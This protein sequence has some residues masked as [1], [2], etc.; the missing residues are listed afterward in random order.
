MGDDKPSDKKYIYELDSS[1]IIDNID[2]IAEH[3]KGGNIAVITKTTIQELDDVSKNYKKDSFVRRSASKASQFLAKL[4]SEGVINQ[5]ISSFLKGDSEK[6][7]KKM[8][9][10]GYVFWEPHF[11]VID[12]YPE[13]TPDN[14]IL[15]TAVH[16]QKLVKTLRDDYHVTLIS[17]DANLRLKA[18]SKDISTSTSLEEMVRHNPELGTK[19][20]KR[21]ELYK[22]YREAY[23]DKQCMDELIQSGKPHHRKLSI[24]K[25]QDYTNSDLSNLCWNEGVILIDREGNKHNTKILTRFNPKDGVIEDL[26]Y[27]VKWDNGQGMYKPKE[28]MGLT[29]GDPLQVYSFE[30]EM[31]PSIRLFISDGMWGTGKTLILMAGCLYNLFSQKQSEGSVGRAIR[32]ANKE[33]L[34]EQNLIILRPEYSSSEFELGPVPGNEED[35]VMPWLKPHI[36]AMK[37]IG[38]INN[39]DFYG[40]LTKNKALEP[41]T[42]AL[43]RGQNIEDIAFIDEVQNGNRHFARLLMGRISDH[44]KVFVSGCSYQIDNEY[45]N[46]Q[47][48]ALTLIK[49][50]YR[51]KGPSI[52]QITLNKNYR[53]N[54][55]RLADGI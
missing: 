24:K 32:K 40:D 37:K 3:T 9:N 51:G 15:G 55:S 12:S 38:N 47:T 42:T 45:V 6:S 28:M 23:V 34:K 30:F 27:A 26:R 31:D 4:L 13:K 10:G 14:R 43:L 20:K 18:A 1:S 33:S 54:I 5:D 2:C 39:Y 21:G 17:E 35:K 44:A 41:W 52:A 50:A 49:E 8:N 53:G 25:L 29:P 11:D 46:V 19:I 36:G 7:F 48:N 16:L 22:G